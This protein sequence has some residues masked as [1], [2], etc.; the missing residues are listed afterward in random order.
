MFLLKILFC[1]MRYTE[2]VSMRLNVAIVLAL[3]MID[4][5]LKLTPCSSVSLLM[6]SWRVLWLRR[7]VR[8]LGIE[9]S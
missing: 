8:P 7:G 3:S 4:L 2:N 1:I 5:C 9:G 6:K